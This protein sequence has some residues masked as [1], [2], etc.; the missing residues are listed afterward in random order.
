MYPVRMMLLKI[1]SYVTGGFS[2]SVNSK[3]ISWILL[4][5][6]LNIMLSCSRGNDNGNET[7]VDSVASPPPPVGNTLSDLGIDESAGVP[8]GL[9]F[10]NKAPGFAA[11]DIMGVPFDL[12]S[13]LNEGPVVLT[14]YRGKWCP[15]CNRHLSNLADSIQ[16]IQE[17]GATLVVVTPELKVN[18]LEMMEK[19]KANFHIISDSGNNIMNVFKVTFKVND[20]YVKQIEIKHGIDIAANNGNKEPK[21]PVPATYIIGDKGDILYVHFDHNYGN[22]APV[23]EILK[24]L[25]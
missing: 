3:M 15:H 16:L 4:F 14:F 23:S 17:K 7:L 25:P 11:H 21:L 5:A 20:L 10:D 2:T 8:S 22:R 1:F 9:R 13:T 24:Y 19:T 12:Y 18:A 6:I